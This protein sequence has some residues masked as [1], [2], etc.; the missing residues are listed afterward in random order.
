MDGTVAQRQVNA[1]GDR[2]RPSVGQVITCALVGRDHLFL[3]LLGGMLQLRRG[4]R[5]VAKAVGVAGHG[6][7]LTDVVV[8]DIDGLGQPGLRLA[9]DIVGRRADVRL[10]LIVA[11]AATFSVP[12]W[13]ADG[14]HALVGK[15]ETFEAMLKGLERLFCDRLPS[16]VTS[17]ATQ[18]HK[19][20]TDREAEVLSLMGEGLTSKEI[21]RVLGRSAHTVQTHR[22]RI[23]G[24]LGRLGSALAR[25]VIGHRNTYFKER[26]P[27]G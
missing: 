18:R 20:L 25:R 23:A 10:V 6:G 17:I 21:A 27:R 9:R 15:D 24:K 1:D 8:L 26:G 22:K 4:L 16:P 11:S 14:S 19:S 13:C 7:L 2:H 12:H 3:D 5:I